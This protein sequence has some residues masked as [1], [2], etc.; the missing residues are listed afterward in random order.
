MRPAELAR[1]EAGLTVDQAAAAS[2]V[3]ERSIR[4]IERGETEKPSAPVLKA[5]AVAY[6]VPVARLLERSA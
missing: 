2:G 5:L 4:R 6:G 1:Y 3:H